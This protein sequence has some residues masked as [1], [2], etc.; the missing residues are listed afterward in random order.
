MSKDL[1]ELA[2]AD[3]LRKEAPLARRVAPRTLDELFYLDAFVVILIGVVF[4]IFC[5]MSHP[6]ET[7][8]WSIFIWMSFTV[9]S[10]VLYVP[11]TPKRT[12]VRK[13]VRHRGR[14]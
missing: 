13:Y 12:F 4:G 7:N 3:R 11:S 1:F 6:S 8:M 5:F 2:A 10:R 14:D 9:F